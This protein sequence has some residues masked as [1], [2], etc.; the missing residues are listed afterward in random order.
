MV[1]LESAGKRLDEIGI[2][3][4]FRDTAHV[5]D[6]VGQRFKEVDSGLVHPASRL[7]NKR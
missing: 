3:S 7:S 1:F 4:G 5:L 6:R 2:Q